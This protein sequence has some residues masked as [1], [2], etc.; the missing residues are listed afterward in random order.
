MRLKENSSLRRFLNNPINF[1]LQGDPGSDGQKGEMGTKGESGQMGPRGLP[2]PTGPAGRRGRTGIR[3]KK[4]FACIVTTSTFGWGLVQATC[5]L[6]KHTVK[7][8]IC[9]LF[10]Y[11]IIA[12]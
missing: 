10:S 6:K 12:R 5:H 11:P 9:I 8:I 3:G 2:G 7:I 1:G 4:S